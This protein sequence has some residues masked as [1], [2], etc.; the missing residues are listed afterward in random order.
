MKR[1][2]SRLFVAFLSYTFFV[3]CTEW[4]NFLFYLCGH[5]PRLGITEAVAA[6][7]VIVVCFMMRNVW[8][9]DKIG[10][11]P[12]KMLGI[13]FIIGIGTFM[14]VFPDRAYDTGNYHLIAQ[15]P[16]FENYFTED[17]AYGN[18][19]VWG[20][21]LPDRM[22]FYFRYLLG[23]RLGTT[24]NVFIMIVSFTQLYDL[25]DWISLKYDSTG[26]LERKIVC[27]RL[28]WSLAILLSLDTILMFGLYYVDLF[29]IPI[30]LELIRLLMKDSK[31][32]KPIDICYFAL[33]SG[34]LLGFKLTNVIYV[35]PIVL[36]YIIKNVKFMRLKD[37]GGAILCGVMPF[38]HYLMFNFMCTGNPVFPYFNGL[39]KSPFFWPS[40]LKDTRWGPVSFFEKIFW[41]VYSAF[42]PK[43]RQCEINNVCSA[44]LIV[45]LF[46]LL[47][48]C[49]IWIYDRKTTKKNEKQPI[50]IWILVTVTLV[51]TILWSFSTGY[52]RYFIFGTMLWGILAYSFIVY[53]S[54]HYAALGKA[55][56]IGCSI[57]VIVCVYS[58]LL[59]VI[60]GTNW[61]WHRY[62]ADEFKNQLMKVFSDRDITKDYD[63]NPDMFIITTQ[64]NMGIAELINDNVYV[65]NTACFQWVGN[66]NQTDYMKRREEASLI[67]DIHRAL[68]FD[69]SD[70]LEKLNENN[71]RMTGMIPVSVGAGDYY[72]VDVVNTDATDLGNTLWVSDE[73]PLEIASMGA[74]ESTLSFICGRYYDWELSPQVF[75]QI[76]KVA[77]NGEQKEIAFVP[78]D[79]RRVQ[80]LSIPI[81]E[82]ADRI[83]I[84]V[85]YSDGSL[86]EEKEQ[87]KVFVINWK[88]E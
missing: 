76:S 42:N 17:F 53:I 56:S 10:F 21:R 68:F 1:H 38:A 36:I 23:Y 84:R 88:Y 47:I 27:N 54:K 64:E 28:V 33:L 4:I 39:F 72:L 13:L 41:I 20:F 67:Y 82:T 35:A 9:F 18:F 87:N 81:E 48:S 83:Q 30:G 45:G 3:I 65:V 66:G 29:G 14:S 49:F 44:V 11:Q 71:L 55:I 60:H 40:N 34:I 73:E 7:L 79:N 16:V 43:Y 26:V 59:F 15:N 62:T 58:N 57:A 31:E 46:G 5:S 6:G 32:Q 78:V 12:E 50:A 74:S 85:C 77:E 24:L 80:L 8:E 22:F 19:Q 86:I 75:L 69:V 2:D 63:V 52:F 51:A 37:W 25:L 70:Y 61:S